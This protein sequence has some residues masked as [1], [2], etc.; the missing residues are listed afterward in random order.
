M[1]SKNIIG[2]LVFSIG[3]ICQI[4]TAFAQNPVIAALQAVNQQCNFD[5]LGEVVDDICGVGY[6]GLSCQ[7]PTRDIIF[8]KPL[9]ELISESC[10]VTSGEVVYH[11]SSITFCISETDLEAC[12]AQLGQ[13]VHSFQTLANMG[14][15]TQSLGTSIMMVK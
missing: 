8:D 9:V 5:N 1:K 10:V 15:Q 3:M 4:G 2:A 7:L 11:D 13:G 12:L 14:G 6:A